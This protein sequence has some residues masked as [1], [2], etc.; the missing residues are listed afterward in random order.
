M[1]VFIS[2]DV[3]V[4]VQQR[5]AAMQELLR[6]AAPSAKWVAADSIHITLKFIGEISEKRLEDIDGA[7]GGL[8]WK[9]IPVAVRGL[10]FFPGIRSPRVLWAG[11]EAATLEA[12]AKEVDSRLVRAGF[13]SEK[14]AFRGHLTLAR[15]KESRLNSALV[16][17]ATPYGETEFGTFLADSIHLYQSTLKAGGSLYTKLKDYAL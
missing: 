16:K 17:E 4:E 11:V 13:D 15:T 3:P 6:P 1:R 9:P 7:L 12:L 8:T 5:L 10:G 14:R 2:I